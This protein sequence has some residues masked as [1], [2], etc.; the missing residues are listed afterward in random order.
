MRDLEGIRMGE[1]R[2]FLPVNSHLSFCDIITIEGACVRDIPMAFNS[3]GHALVSVV[4][5]ETGIIIYNGLIVCS[6]RTV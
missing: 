3:E 2:T 4:S 1:E 6:L 5:T